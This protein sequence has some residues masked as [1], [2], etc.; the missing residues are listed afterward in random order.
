MA[1]R[2]TQKR[3]VTF[4][5]LPETTTTT[6]D[7]GIVDPEHFSMRQFVVVALIVALMVAVGVMVWYANLPPKPQA[8]TASSKYSAVSIE[9]NCY[10]DTY[11]SATQ[12]CSPAFQENNTKPVYL[13][14][15]T[16]DALRKIF[17]AVSTTFETTPMAFGY[18]GPKV[19]KEQMFKAIEAVRST[20]LTAD[21]KYINSMYLVASAQQL[22]DEGMIVFGEMPS[23]L[24]GI[25]YI[26]EDIVDPQKQPTG[27]QIFHPAAL[28]DNQ[29]GCPISLNK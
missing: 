11:L 14:S 7:S 10:V 22:G 20:S 15:E 5:P 21:P 26:T 28:T 19:S 23:T 9:A 13:N 27:S 4:A 12:T 2:N 24:K 6:D 18:K 29:C 8:A 17:P 3:R 25:K 1:K 16:I